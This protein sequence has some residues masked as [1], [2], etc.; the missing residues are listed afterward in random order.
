MRLRRRKKRGASFVVVAH[1]VLVVVA[2]RLIRDDDGL[3]WLVKKS[4]RQEAQ[5]AWSETAQRL[6]RAAPARQAGPG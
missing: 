5:E 2:V 4:K 6:P 3:E 1:L